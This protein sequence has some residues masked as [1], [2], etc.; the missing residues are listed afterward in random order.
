MNVKLSPV[1]LAVL[2]VFSSFGAVTPVAAADSEDVFSPAIL[3]DVGILDFE[4]SVDLVQ[5]GIDGNPSFV[6]GYE[7]GKLDTL[8]SWADDSSSREI[9][10][11][12]DGWAIVSSPAVDI[13]EPGIISESGLATQDYI[14][15][16]DY[17]VEVNVDPI[18]SLDSEDRGAIELSPWER[19]RTVLSPWT[20]DGIAYDEDANET[21]VLDAREYIGADSVS[22]D[23][24]G[25]AVAI[26]DTGANYKSTLYGDSIVAGKDFV[27]DRGTVNASTGDYS[28]I[29]DGQGHGSWVT[30][31]VNDVAPGADLHI[32][33]VLG[34]DGSGSTESI[35]RGLEWACETQNVDVV[36]MSLGSTTYSTAIE[37]QVEDCA[38]DNGVLVIVAAG[39]DRQVTRWVA[40]PADSEHAMAVGATNAADATET[41]SAYFSNVGP[42]SGITDLSQGETREAT[43]DIAAPGMALTTN[44]SE[45]GVTRS[46]TLSGTSMATPLVSG[47]AA[48]LLEANPSLSATDARERLTT[49]ATPLE[50][51][52]TSEVGNGLV[53]A[54]NAISNAVPDETQSQI[55]N[56][57]ADTRDAFNSALSGNFWDL[58]V[59]LHALER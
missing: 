38:E 52:S 40:S 37:S 12:G 56:D 41:A 27:D 3:D 19:A 58:R 24:T 43:I 13:L 42:D 5:Y 55:Q 17:N 34:D 45:N 21:T 20:A 35:V 51:A 50:L 9:Q 18:N 46:K 30:S 32:A 25:V 39:N 6:I 26:L 11:E 7:D 54:G 8:R 47:S 22:V 1:I 29:E 23:G 53:H 16:V 36:S 49:T 59:H 48:L 31:A 14:T 2:L 4:P 33:R 10:Y 28:A 57:D 15:A 44:V